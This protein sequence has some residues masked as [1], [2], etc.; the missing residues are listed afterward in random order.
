[1]SPIAGKTAGTI[2]LTFFVDTHRRLRGVLCL[3]KSDFF[4]VFFSIFFSRATPGSTASSIQR[5][6]EVNLM[7]S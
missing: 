1:M 4:I 6:N 7:R 2:G 3:K 5:E